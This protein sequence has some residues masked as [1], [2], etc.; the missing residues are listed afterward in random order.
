MN[1]KKIELDL[2]NSYS[3]LPIYAK[4]DI[5]IIR[6][7]FARFNDNFFDLNSAERNSKTLALI[8]AR[9][10]SE[11]IKFFSEH[12]RSDK[13]LMLQV[14]KIAVEDG[15]VCRFIEFCENKEL[16]C[17]KNFFKLYVLKTAEV[18]NSQK[19]YDIEFVKTALTDVF[20]KVSNIEFQMDNNKKGTKVKVRKI[21]LDD[22]LND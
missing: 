1:N 13:S 2:Y 5:N 7:A 8:F 20:D 6:N 4:K 17:N 21:T 19:G 10:N 22:I 11:L 9:A 14:F 12:I 16:L 18:L 3:S 15:N